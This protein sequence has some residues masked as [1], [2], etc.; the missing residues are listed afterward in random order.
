MGNGEYRRLEEYQRI[1]VEASRGVLSK[2]N[3]EFLKRKVKEEIHE[4]IIL[5]HIDAR[6]FARLETIVDIEFHGI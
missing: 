2:K 3:Y 4:A 5:G 1:L 6:E